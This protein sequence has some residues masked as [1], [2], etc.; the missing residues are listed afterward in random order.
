[1]D[2]R[3]WHP[4]AECASLAELAA[5]MEARLATTDLFQRAAR[6]PLYRERWRVAGIEPA[7]IRSYADLQQAPYVGPAELRAVQEPA[8][9]GDPGAC[10][11]DDFICSADRPRL[12][13]ST[14]GSTGSPKW[15]PIAA[16]DLELA[17]QMGFRTAYFGDEPARPDDVA[18]GV[19]APAPFISDTSLWPSLL[20]EL[21]RDGPQDLPPV[22]AVV[23]SFDSGADGVAMALKRRATIF[24]AFPSLVMRIAEGLTETAPQV[25]ERQLRAKFTLVNL[26]AYLITRVRKIRARDVLHVHTGIFAGEP[27]DPYR[28][29]LDEA[30]GLKKS[31]NL[32]TFSEYQLGICECEAHEGLHVWVDVSLP[33]IISQADL[34]R[35]HEEPGFV[36]PARP[37]WQAAAGDE[38]EL[39][40]THFGDAFPLVRWRTADLIRVVGVD[41]CRCGRTHPRVQILQRADDLVNLGII[42]FSVFTLQERL[43]AISRPAAVARWQLRVGRLGYKPS[44]TVLIRPAAAVEEDAMVAAVR[45]A[46]DEVEVLRM[47]WQ[48]GLVCEPVVRLVPDLGDRQSTSG[49]F[50]PLVYE[51]NA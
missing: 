29:A 23:F 38:G 39:V 21:R 14:S 22:E 47:G 51:A 36:P 4:D 15:I 16:A 3:F 13:V 8:L 9:R 34:E 30:W 35:E 20:N 12:W 40:M 11:L 1:M 42:R 28:K 43:G 48:N 25:A 2:N 46:L 18:F 10:A 5:R 27:L 19:T 44:L 17:R 31:Y 37:L 49:K 24:L 7:A 33:E 32:F 6:S 41:R 50:R 26:L 45:V